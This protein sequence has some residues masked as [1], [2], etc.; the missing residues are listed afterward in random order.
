LNRAIRHSAFLALFALYANLLFG[1]TLDLDLRH[2]LSR[3][4]PN[5]LQQSATISDQGE[6]FGWR[7]G[8]RL[9]E[10]SLTVNRLLYAGEAHYQLLSFLNVSGRLWQIVRMKADNGTTGGLLLLSARAGITDTVSFT[11][12]LGVQ[13]RSWRVSA[14]SWL[15][16]VYGSDFSETDLAIRFDLAIQWSEQWSS[17]VWLGTFDE[18]EVFNL[19]NPFL[20]IALYRKAI[21]E[22]V[23]GFAF[24]RYQILLGF[25]LVDNWTTGVG[26]RF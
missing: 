4:M 5:T 15:P 7:V 19:H 25:G 11:S 16:V 13:H 23:D 26:V 8:G 22:N 12:R 20:Q 24:G 18:L 3:A 21:W 17:E 14:R 2:Q 1:K 6:S 10:D 9:W